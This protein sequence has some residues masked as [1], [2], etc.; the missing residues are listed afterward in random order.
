MK[1]ADLAVSPISHQRPT[2]D[3]RAKRQETVRQETVGISKTTTTLTQVCIFGKHS[4]ANVCVCV[5]IFLL[6]SFGYIFDE[7]PKNWRSGAKLPYVLGKFLLPST[8]GLR[9]RYVFDQIFLNQGYP[10]KNLSC[11]HLW[12]CFGV[13]THHPRGCSSAIHDESLTWKTFRVTGPLCGEFTDHR[14]IPRS[15]A[16]GVELWCFLWSAL[17]INSWEN[18]REAGDLRRHRAHYDVIVILR[19]VDQ[20]C[21]FHYLQICS[22]Y[23]HLKFLLR[24]CL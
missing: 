7:T 4:L 9:Q 12:K 10:I 19:V 5:C 17:W 2:A 22:K 16:S 20:I 6:K 24:T 14:R 13:P 15:K 1:Q 3:K 21:S 8:I 18:N 11:T 23:L